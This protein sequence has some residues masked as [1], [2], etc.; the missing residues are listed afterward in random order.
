[1]LGN[2]S[3][4]PSSELA[5]TNWIIGQ[6]KER[7]NP[8]RNLDECHDFEL[9]KKTRSGDNRAFETL[10]RRY[11]K[12]VYNVVYQMVRSHEASADLTQDTFLKA[13]R[14]LSNFKSGC[15]FKPWLLKIATNSTL[16]YIRDRKSSS[17]LEELLEVNPAAEPTASDDVEA[18]VELRV[19]QQELF[20][21]LGNLPVRQRQ[22]FILRYQHDLKYEDIAEIT[23][24][25]VS[26]VKSLLFR[27]R[28]NLRDL[29]ISEKETEEKPAN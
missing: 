21:A 2:G 22:V 26:S 6:V 29:L 9:V 18:E 1:M 23:G 11:Q 7:L 19:S 14:A 8:E 27:A 16:N 28:D 4:R 12:L 24:A 17:S 13:Y 20:E 15:S 25:S 10:V 3:I 5:P